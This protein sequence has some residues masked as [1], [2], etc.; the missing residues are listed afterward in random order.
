MVALS[1]SRRLRETPFS[2]G[3]KAAGVK[4]YTVYNHM[5]LPTHG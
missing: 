3:V 1:L 2:E 4:A 5:L